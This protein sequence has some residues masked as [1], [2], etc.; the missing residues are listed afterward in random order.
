MNKQKPIIQVKNLSKRYNGLQAVDHIS[1]DVYEN[2]IFGILG[3][4]GA[5]K[6]TTIEMV[7][8]IREIDSGDIMIDSIDVDKNPDEAKEILGIQLQDSDYFDFLSVKE[9]L[10]LFGEFY[11]QKVDAKEILN[12]V[13]LSQKSK[14]MVKQLSGGQKQRLAVALALVND[15]RILFL[16][17]PTT[18]L[19]PQARR[20][21]WKFIK[22][23]KKEK[24]TM[25]LTTH[26]MEEAETLC[27]RVAIMD[28]GK[29][30]TIDTPDNLINKLLKKGFK[31][32]TKVK[33]ANLEDVFLDL[34]GKKLRD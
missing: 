27:D 25:I 18:G 4:N 22:E 23:L 5:G 16:D 11:N 32:K 34:T 31:K 1:F 15:P 20:H 29:I 7:E 3:P 30:L 33:P 6:S 14:S 17:E 8:G 21:L 24:K 9:I 28:E 2:E 26:Y 10:E 12:K 13:E 19:D